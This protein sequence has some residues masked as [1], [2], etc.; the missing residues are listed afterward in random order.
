MNGAKLFTIGSGLWESL[1]CEG[2]CF[3]RRVGASILDKIWSDYAME[4][5]SE[6]V[7]SLRK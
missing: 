1:P 5:L 4:A 7:G 2:D 3:R 6:A